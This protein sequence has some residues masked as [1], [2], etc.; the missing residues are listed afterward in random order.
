[1]AVLHST[2]EQD[3]VGRILESAKLLQAYI[4]CSDELQA[5]AKVMIRALSDPELDE[6]ER[7][8]AATTLYEILL[9][10]TDDADKLY[11]MDL[12]Q[13]EQTVK[14]HPLSKDSR[15]GKLCNDAAAVLDRMD[16]EETTFADRL[17]DLMKS[18]GI[19][20]TELASR[21]GVGQPAIAMMLKRECRPQKRTVRRL[22]EALGVPP[23]QLWPVQAE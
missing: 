15:D 7:H 6:D 18:V 5:H 17:A 12:E 14:N 11:G 4:E 16:A 23:D 21:A 3:A 19:S 22:A 9:P 20:Q 2:G 10:F 8:L 13:A 1:M